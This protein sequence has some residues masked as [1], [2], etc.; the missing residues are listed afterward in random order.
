VA[1]FRIL[2]SELHGLAI[3]K[4]WEK[5]ILLGD[6]AAPLEY[7]PSGV[8]VPLPGSPCALVSDSSG[9]NEL[10]RA[11]ASLRHPIIIIIPCFAHILALLCGDYLMGSRRSAVIAKS[12]QLVHFFNSSS[13]L[14]SVAARRGEQ[15]PGNDLVGSVCGRNKVDFHVAVRRLSA[16]N[17]GRAAVRLHVV[18]WK[19]ACPG[20]H[21]VSGCQVQES[22]ECCRNR[23]DESF[24]DE[25]GAHLDALLPTLESSL[26]MQGGSVTLSDAI[27]CFA[28]QHQALVA[29][30]ED[31]VIVQLEKRYSRL[32]RPLLILALWLHPTYAEVARA[33]VDSGVVNVMTLAEWVDGYGER[34]EF[35]DGT[36][37]AALAAQD[38]HGRFERG[39]KHS[40]SF[41]VEATKYWRFAETSSPA[42]STSAAVR[43]RQ[44]LA[45]VAGKL[46]SV[47][48]NAADTPSL[49]A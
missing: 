26:V 42:S 30:S 17:T 49:V 28:R 35:K 31:A 44:L 24:F 37:S 2:P 33:M 43:S 16:A 15:H 3:V 32:E 48:P 23:S 18:R 6:R 5:L 20:G 1:L 25:L 29:A 46:L 40:M 13:S 12:Q 22:E 4:G 11:I 39:S 45:Q 41:G 9:P 7:Y 14:A 27:Y 19:V 21:G 47:F 38:W 10:A 36:V 8:A 34:W